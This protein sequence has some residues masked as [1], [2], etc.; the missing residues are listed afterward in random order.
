MCLC[1]S[2][3]VRVCLWV[4][5][6]VCLCLC[7]CVCLCLCLCACV[8][9]A[10]CW[11]SWAGLGMLWV[12]VGWLKGMCSGGQVWQ[13]WEGL[14]SQPGSERV[15]NTLI[16]EGLAWRPGCQ[17]PRSSVYTYISGVCHNMHVFPQMSVYCD[18][19]KRCTIETQYNDEKRLF[20]PESHQ[21]ILTSTFFQPDRIHR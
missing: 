6:R 3:W 17:G 15:H 1:V 9:W 11:G 19:N 7:V 20:F 18:G 5:V 12:G 10:G 16:L 2:V 4:S 21:C 14:A 13:A 8:A